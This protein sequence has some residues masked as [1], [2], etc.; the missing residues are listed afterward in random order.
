MNNNKVK[1]KGRIP[2]RRRRQNQKSF[3]EMADT[4]GLTNIKNCYHNSVAIQRI[5]EWINGKPRKSLLVL[6]PSGCGKTSCVQLVGES[7]N[8]EVVYIN[9]AL[10]QHHDGENPQ[11]IEN[12]I[13]ESVSG[14]SIL[15][16]M[17]GEPPKRK[18]IVVDQIDQY[19]SGSGSARRIDGLMTVLRQYLIILIA[20]NTV[21]KK[22]QTILNYC[23]ELRFKKPTDIEMN[24]ILEDVCERNKLKLSIVAK[25]VIIHKSSGDIN[26]LLLILSELHQ[27]YIGASQKQ[28]ITLSQVMSFINSHSAKDPND[29]NIF[30]C[31][32]RL[33]NCKTLTMLQKYQIY[34]MHA[35]KLPLM[36]HENIPYYMEENTDKMACVSHWF[37]DAALFEGFLREDPER[38][39]KD[40]YIDHDLFATYSCLGPLNVGLGRPK[41]RRKLQFS[42]M[43]GSKNTRR[44]KK[45]KLAHIRSVTLGRLTSISYPG[46]ILQRKLEANDWEG[47][48]S[49]AKNYGFL[50]RGE[51]PKSIAE[52]LFEIAQRLCH[53]NVKWKKP[54]VKSMKPLIKAIEAVP[55]GEIKKDL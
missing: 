21:H 8:C 45:R 2:R 40:L 43:Y 26:Q 31:T 30:S 51:D 36:L 34:D 50:S 4:F 28:Q 35:G 53:M 41:R 1:I 44:S 5:R 12:K 29:D 23:T 14:Y 33:L 38:M 20:T 18:L 11:S 54:T 39:D 16:Q 19:V 9:G 52:M 6:G 27:T 42:K 10:F 7:E 15:T 17:R 3:F 24:R 47:M 46:M 13:Q 25:N 32:E 37:S 48:A 22:M 49:F 55:F